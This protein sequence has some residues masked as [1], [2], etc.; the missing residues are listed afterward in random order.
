MSLNDLIKTYLWN[1]K[2]K[3]IIECKRIPT[4][5]ERDKQIEFLLKNDFEDNESDELKENYK[6][7]FK[8]CWRWLKD[9]KII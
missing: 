5:K 1:S 7:G 4:L 6:I 8:M 3:K 9:D 2:P